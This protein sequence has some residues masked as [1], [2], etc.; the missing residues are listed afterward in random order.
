MNRKIVI[1]GGTGF[2]GRYLTKRFREDGHTVSLISRQ[3][4]HISWDNTRELSGEL[5]NT[6]I[7]IN[8]AG[9]SV[10]KR[11]TETNRT[12][13]ISSRT[14]STGILGRAI[15]QCTYKPELWI[16]ASGAHIYGTG[17]NKSHT[18]KD[19]VDKSGFFLSEMAAAWENAFFSFS[20]ADMRQVALRIS[21]VLG[22]GGGII[23]QMTP[24]VKMGLGGKQGNGRQRI[25]W[26]H[27]EDIYQIILFLYRQPNI[28]GPVNTT[29]PDIINN[30]T[31]MAMMRTVLGISI[32]LPTPTFAMKL[33]AY[34]LGMEADLALK[35]LSVLPEI[36]LNEGYQ[37]RYPDI[38][39]A[40]EDVLRKDH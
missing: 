34:M 8:L 7:L 17:D 2:V 20:T 37:F 26:I 19:P 36:L 23:K 39:S 35:S 32:G 31:F 27:L 1:A 22:A 12:E 3:S 29:S 28:S 5:E 6:N 24:I 21:M 38:R 33:G 16:N 9:T 13:M 11:F 25:S 10:N 18:E 40:L 4:G 15:Q 14:E 30:Q